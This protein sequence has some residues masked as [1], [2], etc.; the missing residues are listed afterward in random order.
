MSGFQSTLKSFL[1]LLYC[2]YWVSFSLPIMHDH[3]KPNTSHVDAIESATDSEQ[4]V[5]VGHKNDA[6]EEIVQHLQNTGEEVG[7]TWRTY[8]AA[9]VS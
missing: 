3:E 8:M 1:S 7:M 4:N 5:P 2:G 9:I 6:N